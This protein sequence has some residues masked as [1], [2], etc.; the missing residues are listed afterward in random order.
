MAMAPMAWTPVA[1]LRA[2]SAT[3]SSGWRPSARTTPALVPQRA[4]GSRDA[5]ST[6]PEAEAVPTRLCAAGRF[7]Q[8]LL[9]EEAAAIS[10]W[11]RGVDVAISCVQKVSTEEASVRFA[12][13]L[14]RMC[15]PEDQ[16]WTHLL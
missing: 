5:A 16:V 8:P 12:F 9:D 3:S 6:W 10:E 15:R 13:I 7:Q 2:D 14:S 11:I 1:P 4:L